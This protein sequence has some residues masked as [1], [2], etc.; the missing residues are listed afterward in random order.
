MQRLEGKVALVTGAGRG[1]G[2]EYALA[3]AREGAAVVVNDL[4]GAL[5]G[6]GADSSLAAQVVSEIETIGGRAMATDADV[7]DFAAAARTVDAAVERFGRLDVLIANA[8]IVRRGPIVE[9]AEATWDSVI[10]TNL[11]GTFNYVHHAARAMTRQGSGRILTITSGGSFIPSPRSAPYASSKAAILS[12][13]LC[14]AA[15]L[16]SAGITVNCLSPGLTDTRLGE[17]A[18]ADITKSSGISREAFYAE[19]G[20]PQRPDALAPLAVFLASDEA[21]AISGRIF[22]VAGERILLVHPP[23]RG[24]IFERPGG[25]SVDGVFASFPRRF[26]DE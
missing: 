2:R 17:G 3:L 20:A 16:E 11:K 10:E 4:G 21:R 26:D 24:R 1:I 8:A 13:T 7:S 5:E 12:F 6:G 22:E 9:C 15:E 14:V 25:W 23:S 18:I 19:V